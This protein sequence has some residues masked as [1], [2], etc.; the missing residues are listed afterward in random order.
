VLDFMPPRARAPDLFRIAT[1]RRGA[2]P[3]RVDLV[4]R[5]DYGAIVPWVQR[6][7][8]G[9]GI[10]AVAGPDHLRLLASVPLHGENYH[11]RGE[12]TLKEGER[13]TFG[14]S[15]APS[16][17]EAPPAQ[18]PD[19]A[20]RKTQSFWR[21]WVGRCSSPS[22]SPYREYEVRSLITLKALTYR[23]TGGI[24]AA[25]T[26]SLPE[27]LGGARNWDYRYC[28]LR[29]ATFTLDALLMAGY[30]EEADAW[31]RWLLRAVAGKPSQIQILYG[32]RGERRLPEMELGFL[33]GYE[34][35]RPVRIGN[36]AAGQVQLDV[37]GELLDSMHQ[38]RTAG[39]CIDEEGWLLQRALVEHLTTVWDQPDEGI[40]EVRGGRRLFTHS[41]VMAW[42]AL[43]RAIQAVERFGL[44][45][46][47]DSLRRWHAL[48]RQIH[49]QVCR[50][51]FDP[52]L[53]SFVQSYGSRRL[54]ASLLLLP[55]VGFL[56]IEDPRVQGTVAAIERELLRDG[57]VLRYTPAESLDGLPGEEGAFL[58]C[59]FWLVDNYVLLG[60][61][62]DAHRLFSRLLSLCN[63]VGLLS[64]E[65]D[66]RRGRLTGNFPQAFS[67]V[68]LINSARNLTQAGGPA[69]RRAHPAPDPRPQ[70]TPGAGAGW[71][72][73]EGG[74]FDPDR[75][76]DSSAERGY[77][78][79]MD[80][81]LYWHEF[82]MKFGQ[83]A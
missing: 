9:Y 25:P 51:G 34:G 45:C 41:R 70:A 65:Y 58:A 46:Q 14:L 63:D 31:R 83:I 40:W 62:Q 38:A 33:P 43:D 36:G 5:F 64:E 71:G 28:W 10:D 60:R 8:E 47:E 16:Y 74:F 30:T 54:D 2:V 59:S 66:W 52:E 81:Q 23:P 75:N 56:P 69:A 37:Y 42:V 17:G 18:D 79:S 12:F 73:A 4:I 3:M 29:D 76:C 49:E 20:L 80:Q 11:T 39:L 24:V 82:M 57:L 61:R 27:E 72:S 44:C 67:H 7:P 77:I 15:W 78:V 1:C 6:L 35:S 68:G 19:E 26:T 13:A 48:R 53:G 22:G 55:L 32:L 50:R 21:A